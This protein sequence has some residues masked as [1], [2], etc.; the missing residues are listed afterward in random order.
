MATPTSLHIFLPWPNV[1][2]DIILFDSFFSAGFTWAC[3]KKG[4]FVKVA[5]GM[6]IAS[7]THWILW[8]L[9]IA[10]FCIRKLQLEAQARLVQVATSGDKDTIVDGHLDELMAAWEVWVN[11]PYLNLWVYLLPNIVDV[12]G[13]I[14]KDH[15]GYFFEGIR[16]TMLPFRLLARVSFLL[17]RTPVYF[18]ILIFFF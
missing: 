7:K 15:V 16:I 14:A 6:K 13:R 9:R 3:N 1:V 12:Y 5:H 10:R 18:S 8:Y 17:L 4:V 2:Y 11:F